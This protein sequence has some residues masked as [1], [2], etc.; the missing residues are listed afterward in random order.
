M[1]NSLW[2]HQLQPSR[3]HCPWDFPGKNTWVGC[4]FLL[5][6]IFQPRERICVSCFSCIGRWI[7][8]YWATWRSLIYLIV[9]FLCVHVKSLQSCPTLCDPIDCS[10]P[11]FSVHGILQV[12]TL[13]WAAMPSFRG[14]SW[15]RDWIWV[16]CVSWIGRWVL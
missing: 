1:S 15:P 8:Y 16:S 12:R 5:K 10:P 11:S 7:L 3:L 13:E 4:H 6:G 9:F 14:S 2:P